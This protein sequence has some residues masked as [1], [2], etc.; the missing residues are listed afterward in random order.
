MKWQVKNQVLLGLAASLCL[1]GS[2]AAKLPA[3]ISGPWYNPDQ[4]GHG[5]S[6]DLVAADRAVVF[7][8]AY[9]N[10][11]DPMTLYIEGA[12]NGREIS[13]TA[14][15]PRGM[16]FGQ[17]NPADLQL[18]VWGSVR[19][20]FD[21]CSAGT[22]SWD[23]NSPDFVDGSIVMEKLAFL[24]GVACSLPP[25]NDL[26]VTLV[27]GTR[28]SVDNPNAIEVQGILD[29]EGRLWSI[30]RGLNIPGP[31]WV[32]FNPATVS[33]IEPTSPAADSALR[34]KGFTTAA[35]AL[36]YN[37]LPAA[38]YFEGDWR[39]AV[40]GSLSLR[41][42]S[43]VPRLGSFNRYQAAPPSGYQLVAP[44]ALVDLGRGFSIKS[45]GQFFEFDGSL[46]V[47][48]HGQACLKIS[49]NAPGVCDF[50]GKFAAG[51]GEFGLFDFE[52]KDQNQPLAGPY[53]G[54]GWLMDGPNG[55]ELILVGSSAGGV[56]LGVIGQ[57]R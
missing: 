23:A 50:T 53:R 33:V 4:S 11:G 6:V 48:G 10:Q 39:R 28:P 14:Y 2:A 40:D 32:G 57:E 43:S 34:A 52:L 22:L 8:Y 17:F 47:D 42:D 15:A 21:S 25:V 5:I 13:G 7:W 30:D 16:R 29:R 12:V 9:D 38:G 36:T 49:T 44:V 31:T 18:P 55:R 27:S 41:P 24:D 54:R 19:L 51:E 35:A 3:G 46:S 20:N 1:V 56:G 37:P 26:P 45:R